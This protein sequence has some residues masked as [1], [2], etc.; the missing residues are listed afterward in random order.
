LSKHLHLVTEVVDLVFVVAAVL[1]VEAK[2][3]NVDKN[4]VMKL[5]SIFKILFFLR[6]Q[7]TKH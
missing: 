7:M 1:L 2:A 6:D 3:D 4:I 5:L